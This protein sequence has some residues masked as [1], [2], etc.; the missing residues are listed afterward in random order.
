MLYII[1][2]PNFGCSFCVSNSKIIVF[3]ATNKACI[4]EIQRKFKNEN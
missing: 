1:Q 4:Y 2:I 3:I